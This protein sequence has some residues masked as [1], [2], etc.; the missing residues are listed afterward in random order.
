MQIFLGSFLVSRDIFNIIYG[1]AGD[2]C[3]T[4]ISLPIIISIRL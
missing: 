3:I 4:D 1:D 2:E